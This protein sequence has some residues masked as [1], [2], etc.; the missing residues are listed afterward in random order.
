MRGKQLG[1]NSLSLEVSEEK[2]SQDYHYKIYSLVRLHSCVSRSFVS[3]KQVQKALVLLLSDS[4]F[5]HVGRKHYYTKFLVFG[6]LAFYCT[7]GIFSVCLQCV[8][9][10]TDSWA[11]RQIDRQSTDQE[12]LHNNL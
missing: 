7:L 4:T 2:Y 5:Q 8:D 3:S 10:M 1:H 12:M 6:G 9:R 11:D